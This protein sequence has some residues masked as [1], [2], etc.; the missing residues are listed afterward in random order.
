MEPS[1]FR[2]SQPPTSHRIPGY[3]PLVGIV[4]PFVSLTKAIE[5]MKTELSGLG[6]HINERFFSVSQG[7][8]EMNTRFDECVRQTDRIL[9]EQGARLETRLEGIQNV[10][11]QL[12]DS[13]T[14]DMATL[15]EKSDTLKER[16]DTLECLTEASRKTLDSKVATFVE[17]AGYTESRFH[18]LRES[19]GALPSV[20]WPQ[21]DL[22]AETTS[23]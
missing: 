9:A 17:M 7:Y 5:T 2:G 23:E 20:E 21:I 6:W 8:T 1:H 3:P 16:L 19:N 11:R 15:K 4:D 10:I 13:Q 14:A 22:E 12:H 18:H